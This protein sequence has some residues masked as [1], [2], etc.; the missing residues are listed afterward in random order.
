MSLIYTTKKNQTWLAVKSPILIGDTSDF[1]W[2]D[3]S[4]VMRS[5]VQMPSFTPPFA[6]PKEAQIE[7]VSSDGGWVENEWIQIGGDEFF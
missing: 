3:F 2:L 7:T 6:M 4:I 1:K 5:R